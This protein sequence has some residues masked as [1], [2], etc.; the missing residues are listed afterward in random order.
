VTAVSKKEEAAKKKTKAEGREEGAAKDKAKGSAVPRRSFL[1]TLSRKR[2][3]FR[4]HH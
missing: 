2:S 3:A 1:V 4:E